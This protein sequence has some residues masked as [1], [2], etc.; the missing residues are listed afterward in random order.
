MADLTKGTDEYFHSSSLFF[1]PVCGL[2][3]WKLAILPPWYEWFDNLHFLC[4]RISPQDIPI[5]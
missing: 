5:C 4:Y 2:K 1:V 3:W